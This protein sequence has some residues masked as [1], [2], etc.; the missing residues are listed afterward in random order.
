MKEQG[1]HE[2]FGVEELLTEVPRRRVDTKGLI[3][4]KGEIS[5]DVLDHIVDT[6]GK[7]LAVSDEAKTVETDS[8]HGDVDEGVFVAR[9][10]ES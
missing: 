1:D 6:L 4:S 2:I 5:P 10:S 9:D 8:D 3:T 7:G